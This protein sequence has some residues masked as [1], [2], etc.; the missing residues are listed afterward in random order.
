MN[1]DLKYIINQAKKIVFEVAQEQFKNLNDKNI[2]KKKDGSFVTRFDLS[3]DTYLTQELSKAFPDIKF[4]SEESQS[5]TADIPGFAWCIDP[6]DGTHNFMMDI[7]YYAVSV[8]L[9]RDGMP[10]AGVI[11]DPNSHRMISGGEDLPLMLNDREY[12]ISNQSYIVTTNRSHQE[13]D[14]KRESEYITQILKTPNLKYRRLG[15]CAL[16]I[17]NLLTGSIGAVVIIGNSKWDWAA[18]Y[19]IVKNSTLVIHQIEDLIIMSSQ[20]LK[21][22]MVK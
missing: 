3:I 11:Y 18:G 6:I 10:V 20:H 4:I 12:V 9:L 13:K 15:S 22:A 14:K 7:P 21:E 8:G 5:N 1:T 16:D 17:M 2:N 19:A